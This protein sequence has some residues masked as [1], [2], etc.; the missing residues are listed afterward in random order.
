MET[1]RRG[2]SGRYNI[3]LLEGLEMV[4]LECL[5]PEIWGIWSWDIKMNVNTIAKLIADTNET[6]LVTAWEFTGNKQPSHWVA[7]AIAL[8]RLRQLMG[9]NADHAAD[10]LHL[11]ICELNNVAYFVTDDK[12]YRRYV[13]NTLQIASKT[14]IIGSKELLEV[15]GVE[16]VP[17]P[18]NR[19][20]YALSVLD[21]DD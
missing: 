12:K 2:R 5:Q 10:A 13:E 15:L 17:F 14:K 6:E 21:I 11:W 3:N 18:R 4:G 19:I 9:N 20:D 1:R 8:P 16:K 7:H